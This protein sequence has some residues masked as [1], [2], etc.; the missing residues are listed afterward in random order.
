MTSQIVLINQSG[1]GIA[2]DTLVSR[3]EGSNSHKTF[4]SSNKI[5]ELGGQHKVVVLHSGV[6]T[7][8]GLN[9]GLLIREWALQQI[10]PLPSLSDYPRQFENWLS[11]YRKLKINEDNEIYE[12]LCS[13]FGYFAKNLSDEMQD[14]LNLSEYEDE[15]ISDEVKQQLVESIRG[16]AEEYYVDDHPYEDITDAAIVKVVRQQERGYIEHFLEHI[17]FRKNN[18]VVNWKVDAEITEAI[19]YFA[20]QRLK[21][22]NFSP[23]QA[24]LNFVGFGSDE[25]IGGRVEV[26]VGGFYLNRLRSRIEKREPDANESA[27]T[28]ATIAQQDAMVDFMRGLH[29][30]RQETYMEMAREIAGNV[31][32]DESVT[33]E[34]IDEFVKAYD[35]ALDESLR[36][37]FIRPFKRTLGA[38][39]IRS[40]VL[41]SEALVKI[42]SLRSATAPGEATVGGLIE[43]LSIDRVQG[44]EWHVRGKDTNYQTGN[45]PHPFL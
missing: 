11:N 40:L 35:E 16:Y 3:E 43:S 24:T 10:T 25:P 26:N 17:A 13:S 23:N 38:L 45:S 7:L 18:D 36:V 8:G 15:K 42:Q 21:H 41:F 37:D 6:T 28:I 2:S 33:S 12:N 32:A 19:E 22:W 39:S 31:F 30:S 9:Y 27:V 29:W 14:Q 5:Y 20:I 44:I 34:K 1:I 4:P